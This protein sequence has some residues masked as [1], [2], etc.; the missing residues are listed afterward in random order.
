MMMNVSYGQSLY[1]M[2]A[3][4]RNLN[5]TPDQ[6]TSIAQDFINRNVVL[7]YGLGA[8]ETYPGYYKF[9]TTNSAGK[10]GMDIMVNGYNGKI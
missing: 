2:T 1:K 6:A 7:D 3:F 5:L 9:H 10:F 4:G 8:P